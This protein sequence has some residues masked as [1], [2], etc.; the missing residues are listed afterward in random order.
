MAGSAA[1]E[2]FMVQ[3][4]RCKRCGRLLTSKRAVADGYGHVCLMKEI[5]EKQ[6]REPLPGQMGFFED[7]IEEATE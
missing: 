3:A 1:D 4:R 2:I 7:E 5:G 6:A